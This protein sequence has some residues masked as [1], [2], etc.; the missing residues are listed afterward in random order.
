MHIFSLRTRLTLLI[1]SASFIPALLLAL[2]L[3]DTASKSSVAALEQRAEAQ[4]ISVR[5]AKETVLA[6]YFERLD[7]Q[8]QLLAANPFTLNA[9]QDFV[10]GVAQYRQQQSLSAEQA[11]AQLME[12]YQQTFAPRYYLTNQ[13]N[14]IDIKDWIAQ[15]EPEQIALQVNY[16]VNNPHPLGDK[17]QLYSLGD[18]TD[19]DQAHK[20]Y[21]RFFKET[22]YTFGLHDLVI[23]SAQTNT[24]LYSVFKETDFATSLSSGPYSNSGLAN[25][26]FATK[27]QGEMGIAALE[28]LSYY[29]PSY[30]A[31]AMFLA[32]PVMYKGSILAVLAFQLPLDKINA[33]MSDNQSWQSAGLGQSGESYIL[34]TDNILRSELRLAYENFDDYIARLQQKGYDPG[35]INT[36]THLKQGAGIQRVQGSLYDTLHKELSGT[37]LGEDALGQ[38]VLAAFA[39]VTI[40]DKRWFLVSQMTSEEAFQD[41]QVLVTSMVTRIVAVLIVVFFSM[42]L[43]ALLSSRA[44]VKPLKMII[45]NLQVLSSGQG[46]LTQRLNGEHRRDEFGQLSRAFNQFTGFIEQ[47][48]IHVRTTSADLR[49]SA[50][51]LSTLTQD[52]QASLGNQKQKSSLVATSMY[53]LSANVQEVNSSIQGVSEKSHSANSMAQHIATNSATAAQ[54]MDVMTQK[55]GHAYHQMQALA[56]QVG[57]IESVLSVI[58]SIA[59]Q[60]N[61]LALNA[62]IEAARAGESGRGFAVVADEVRTLAAK[63]QLSTVEIQEKITQFKQIS[64]Q[65]LDSMQRVS[66]QADASASYITQTSQSISEVSTHIADISRLNEQI[67]E[68]ARQQSL[69]SEEV[70][71]NMIEIDQLSDHSSSRSDD[72]A[73]AA[74]RLSE[75]SNNLNDL[76]AR[77]KLNA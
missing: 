7:T 42:S 41:A 50:Q 55:T 46:D 3:F 18:G 39:P 24:V 65:T 36:I 62:A 43:V 21:H 15:L 23:I 60:T 58:D 73:L 59:D 11:K 69:A 38:S 63:T 67:L 76:V 33:I 57:S 14:P 61:L 72:V 32:Y 4:L 27:Q 26:F 19:Y 77:F 74:Q 8:I 40:H 9:A 6:A 2:F 22:V 44:I 51:Q 37:T 34:G 5:Q 16:I 17:D 54:T 64:Q 28:D 70:S 20:T 30:N 75:L 47:L 52:T 45:S 10:K 49:Q 29:E 12:Y 56:A 1:L 71:R 35:L 31:P 48:L 13:V 25:V 66:Q 53:Q 68:A